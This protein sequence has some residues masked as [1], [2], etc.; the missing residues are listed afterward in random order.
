MFS[1]IRGPNEIPAEPGREAVWEAFR[2][3]ET[4]SEGSEINAN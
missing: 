4:G 2:G 1:A 3:P